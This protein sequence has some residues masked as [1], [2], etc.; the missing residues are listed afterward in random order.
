MR[1]MRQS[2]IYERESQQH[3][4]HTGAIICCNILC[5][6]GDGFN[7]HREQDDVA[8]AS[9]TLEGI[10]NKKNSH[11]HS[12]ESVECVNSGRKTAHHL[13]KLHGTGFVQ[14]ISSLL[15]PCNNKTEFHTHLSC[16][17]GRDNARIYH[18][19]T[20]F[21][22]SAKPRGKSIPQG[23]TRVNVRK[24]REKC[25]KNYCP[26]SIRIPKSSE[27]KKI[28]LFTNSFI[29]VDCRSQRVRKPHFP[30]PAPS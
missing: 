26:E 1:F 14:Y 22:L 2:S 4:H 21:S 12:R 17:R 9:T 20:Y 19:K 16:V 30:S 6:H 24:E 3:R 18:A 23:T 11:T 15:L 7:S 25:H 5:D 10:L 13:T 28:V 27:K 8:G 29:A